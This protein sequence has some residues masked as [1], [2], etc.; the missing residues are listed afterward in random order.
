[1]KKSFRQPTIVAF[2][3]FLRYNIM[4]Y[5]QGGNTFERKFKRRRNAKF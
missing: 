4:D 5:Q 3:W 1:M 2:I